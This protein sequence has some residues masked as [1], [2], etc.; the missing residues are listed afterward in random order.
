M[1]KLEET[2]ESTRNNRKR[3]PEKRPSQSL[4]L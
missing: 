1:T 4:L 2:E 3:A